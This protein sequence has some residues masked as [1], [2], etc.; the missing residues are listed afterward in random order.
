MRIVEITAKPVSVTFEAIFGGAE[1]VP[2]SLSSPASHFV[3]FKRTGQHSTLVRVRT[4]DGVEGFGEA[5]GLPAPEVSAAAVNHAIAPMFLDLDPSEG[6]DLYEDAEK[7]LRNLGHSRGPLMEAL[8]AVDMALWDI[9]GKRQGTSIAHQL[10]GSVGPVRAYASPVAFSEHIGDAVGA[11][12]QFIEAGFRGFKIKVGR[13]PSHDLDAIRAIRD[14]VGDDIDIMLDAN[15]AFDVA[16]AIEFAHSVEP[17]HPTWLEEPVPPDN[18]DAL[19]RVR[20]E[21]DIPIAWGENEFTLHGVQEAVRRQAIDIAQPNVTRAGG[22]TGSKRIADFC[23][24]EG[25]AFAPHGVGT[26]I[27]ISAMLHVCRATSSFRVYEANRLLNP[28][29]DKLIQPIAPLHDGAFVL[30]DVHGIGVHV[31]WAT[32]DT[33]VTELNR[34]G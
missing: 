14:V 5:F 22:V 7:H 20:R 11:A 24:D 18:L 28:L 1:K 25:I 9:Q 21:T 32:I 6:L 4:D 33:E 23:V 13:D 27:G 29:R 31:D 30:P 2:A 8:G 15:G 34:N 16:T 3:R 19:R 26:G 10:G 12:Q 17:F